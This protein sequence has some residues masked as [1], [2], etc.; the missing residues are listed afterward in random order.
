M[1]ALD[2][3]AIS[4]PYVQGAATYSPQLIPIQQTPQAAQVSVS[5]PPS[6]VLLKCKK[7]IACLHCMEQ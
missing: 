7:T 2:K 4:V 6:M 3:Q 5:A 1:T